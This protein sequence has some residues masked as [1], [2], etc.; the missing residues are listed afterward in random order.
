[1]DPGGLAASR[2]QVEHK[3]SIKRLMATINFC[4]PILKH[5]TQTFRPTVDAAQD[6]VEV[7]VGSSFNGKRA[8]YVG[9]N[10]SE[11][12]AMNKDPEVQAKLWNGCWRWASMKLEETVLSNTR[13]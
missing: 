13:E 11:S 10:S 3:P 12:A 7:S 5:F 2:S 8:Y 1:M 6:L 4:M 9:Q